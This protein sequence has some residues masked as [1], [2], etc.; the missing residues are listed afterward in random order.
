MLI[1]P[2]I[3]IAR[4]HRPIGIWLLGWPIVWA[5]WIA[6]QGHPPWSMVLVFVVGV[7]LTRSAGCVI[8]DI[9]DRRWDGKVER[10]AN[11][12]LVTGAISLKAAWVWCGILLFC[13]GL[14]LFA[15]A[16]T[17]ILWTWPALFLMLVYPYTKRWMNAPQLVLGL[18]FASGIPMVFSELTAS[19]SWI[20]FWLV[21]AAICWALAYDTAYALMDKTDDERV[22]IRSTARCWGR[23]VCEGIFWHEVAMLCCLGIVG[24]LLLFNAFYFVGL[25]IVLG[26]FGWQYLRLKRQQVSGWVIFLEH[27]WIGPLIWLN[28]VLSQYIGSK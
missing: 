28:I 15:L 20:T 17:A 14:L 26:V 16:S 5:L 10:T 23:W 9:A 27:Q 1:R 11:R 25:G 12:P 2:Y 3:E 13:A 8:N 18:A 6:G 24:R 7:V 19:V 4:L 21:L 22:G